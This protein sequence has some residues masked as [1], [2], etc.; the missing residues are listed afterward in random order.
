M[1]QLHDTV[2]WHSAIIRMQPMALEQVH[3]RVEALTPSMQTRCSGVRPSSSAASTGNP[4]PTSIFKIWLCLAHAA[5][6]TLAGTQY[7]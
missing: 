3:C 1:A 6:I 5:N 2:P 7:H 4:A